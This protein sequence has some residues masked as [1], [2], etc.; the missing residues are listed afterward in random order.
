MIPQQQQVTLQFHSY[1]VECSTILHWERVLHVDE[2]FHNIDN[3]ICTLL[4]VKLLFFSSHYSHYSFDLRSSHLIILCG[5]G[6]VDR[7]SQ[8]RQPATVS[9]SNLLCESPGPFERQTE[10]KTEHKAIT[11]PN[12]Y[13][14]FSFFFFSFLF[15]FQNI[16]NREHTE[17]TQQNWN[18]TISKFGMNFSM[19]IGHEISKQHNTHKEK[20]SQSSSTIASI[21][22]EKKKR[23]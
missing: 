22:L 5:F 3:R 8:V 14:F 7:E 19:C 21:E 12:C 20:E 1:I 9:S 6:T 2:A 10:Q 4:L 13:V 23:I 17:L 11:Q 18:N 15:F 16:Y